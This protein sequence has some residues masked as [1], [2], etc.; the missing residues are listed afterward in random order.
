LSAHQ[1]KTL[2]ITEIN[3]GKRYQKQEKEMINELPSS[4]EVPRSMAQ[5][6]TKRFS[7]GKSLEL[8]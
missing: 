6:A 1:R 4:G 8:H 5:G 2:K 7:R 3:F